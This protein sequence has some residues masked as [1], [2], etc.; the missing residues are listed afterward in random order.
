[1][2]SLYGVIAVCSASVVSELLRF[3]VRLR[4]KF[5]PD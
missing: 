3:R 1:M 2:T 5:H 4:V